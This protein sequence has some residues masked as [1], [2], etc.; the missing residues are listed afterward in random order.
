MNEWQQTVCAALFADAILKVRLVKHWELTPYA[1]KNS[2]ER[3]QKRRDTNDMGHMAQHRGPWSRDHVLS[4][5]HRL[6]A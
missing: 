1:R 3:A 5:L 2:L 4:K 6:T